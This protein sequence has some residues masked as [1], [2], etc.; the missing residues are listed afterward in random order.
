[1]SAQESIPPGSFR[2]PLV[3]LTDAEVHALARGE[4]TPSMKAQLAVAS[5][6]RFRQPHP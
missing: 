2:G 6:P 3:A 4:V 1:M 5:D